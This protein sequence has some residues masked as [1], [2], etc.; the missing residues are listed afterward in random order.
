[1]K[2]TI[3]QEHVTRLRDWFKAGRGVCC[4]QNLEIASGA[5]REVFT[6]YFQGTN[7]TETVS[8]PNWRYGNPTQIQPE[9]ITVETFEV[10]ETFRGRFK[11]MYWGPW[12]GK[13]T[14]AKAKRLCASHGLPEDS[15]QWEHDTA[16]YVIVHIGRTTT[17]PFEVTA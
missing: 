12:V 2:V 6:P 11:A 4:W 8:A 5:S 10:I 17:A 13:A 3:D 15:W 7:D 9:D 1:M 16:G 14:E